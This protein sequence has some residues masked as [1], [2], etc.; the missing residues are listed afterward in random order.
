MKYGT[1]TRVVYYLRFQV[2]KAVFNQADDSTLLRKGAT[3][4]PLYTAS[5]VR[6]RE[7]LFAPWTSLK[8]HNSFN[9]ATT[10]NVI[11]LWQYHA[12]ARNVTI[13]HV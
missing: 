12:F 8:R 2:L 10:V 9:N 11:T 6:R 5:H 4:T 7:C 13:Q 1:V 3:Y